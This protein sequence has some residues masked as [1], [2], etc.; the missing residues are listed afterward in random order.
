MSELTAHLDLPLG[1]PAV[2][3]ARRVV[4][5]MLRGWGLTDDEWLDR[6]SLVVSELVTNAVR[7]GGGCLALD[8]RAD[9][10]IVTVGAADASALVPRRGEVY[11]DGTGGYGIGIIEALASRWGVDDQEGG[12]RVWVRLHPY[13]QHY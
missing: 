12:K 10:G 9:E 1:L 5:S 13:G 2:K 8:L 3:A 4:R 6:A 11:E 7:H